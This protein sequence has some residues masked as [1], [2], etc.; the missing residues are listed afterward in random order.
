[1]PALMKYIE[2][3]TILSPEDIS[4]TLKAFAEG[5]SNVDKPTATS[6]ATKRKEPS[7][8]TPEVNIVARGSTIRGRGRG[9][10]YNGGRGNHHSQQ[11]SYDNNHRGSYGNRRGSHRSNNSGGY[12]DPSKRRH[13]EDR[14]YYSEYRKYHYKREGTRCWFA[15]P[16]AAPD[17]WSSTPKEDSRS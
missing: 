7:D 17:Y 5:N 9:R 15:N 3:S 6:R 16:D 8:D 2:Q 4:N 12:D 1:M 13:I 14:P 10:S 11:E